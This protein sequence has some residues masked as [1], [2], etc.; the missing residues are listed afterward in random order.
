MSPQGPQIFFKFVDFNDQQPVQISLGPD[1][2]VKPEQLCTQ[3]S[4]VGMLSVCVHVQQENQNETMCRA[5]YQERRPRQGCETESYVQVSS[6]V[7]RR[8]CS[9]SKAIF[10]IFPAHSWLQDL[11]EP[12]W[13]S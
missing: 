9:G 13:L 7:E 11:L 4:V 2:F 8:T 10:S 3:P 6:L 1:D 5:P 12:K